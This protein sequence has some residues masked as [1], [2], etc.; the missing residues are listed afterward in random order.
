LSITGVLAEG[1]IC[2]CSVRGLIKMEVI[3]TWECLH[4]IPTD[5]LRESVDAWV[6][7]QVSAGIQIVITIPDTSHFLSID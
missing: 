1:A 5:T 7:Y 3:P 2:V 4:S 6:K